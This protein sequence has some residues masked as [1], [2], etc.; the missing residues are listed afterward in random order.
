MAAV[1]VFTFRVEGV[2]VQQ[3]ALPT[4]PRPFDETYEIEGEHP[5][6]ALG[7]I[8]HEIE[9]GILDSEKGFTVTFVARS[10][11]DDV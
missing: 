5:G 3:T 9:W 10:E 2:E 7:K 8:P 1:E 6:E 11:G 4:T